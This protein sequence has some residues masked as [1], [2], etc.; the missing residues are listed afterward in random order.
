MKIRHDIR[1]HAALR[2]AK[3]FDFTGLEFKPG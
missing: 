3:R 1:M 2:N